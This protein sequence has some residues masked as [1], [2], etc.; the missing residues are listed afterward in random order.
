MQPRHKQQKVRTTTTIAKVTTVSD[1]HK[2]SNIFQGVTLIFPAVSDHLFS[3]HKNSSGKNPRLFFCF[4]FCCLLI[5]ETV[6][7]PVFLFLHNLETSDDKTCDTC[8][9]YT[10]TTPPELSPMAV[11]P[12][13]GEFEK[14]PSKF[15]L[16]FSLN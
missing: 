12:V 16:K 11:K 15:P 5:S 6:F 4:S 8:S 10:E 2:S 9:S 13:A 3:F 14:L 1:N 7:F